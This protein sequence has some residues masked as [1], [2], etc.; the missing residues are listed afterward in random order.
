[1]TLFYKPDLDADWTDHTLWEVYFSRSTTDCKKGTMTGIEDDYISI[2]DSYR[3]YFLSMPVVGARLDC[4]YKDLTW[5]GE[6]IDAKTVAFIFLGQLFTID[7]DSESRAS[8]GY[9][10]HR[11]GL[12]GYK[13][14]SR[15][16]ILSDEQMTIHSEVDSQPFS[17]CRQMK[18]SF[19]SGSRPNRVHGDSWNAT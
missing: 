15:D 12:S 16:I 7:Y 13:V 19:F 9:V 18:S 2:H 1:M 6:S 14:Q 4:F 3:F 5:I 8:H 11:Q 10:L 17:Q